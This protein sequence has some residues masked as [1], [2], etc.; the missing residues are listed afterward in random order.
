MRSV[1]ALLGLLLLGCPGSSA[2]HSTPQP[3]AKPEAQAALETV[4]VEAQVLHGK[5]VLQGELSPFEAVALYPRVS[6]FI[7]SIAVDRGSPVRAGQILARLSAPELQAQRAEAEA[8][9]RADELT[10]QRLRTASATPG[11]VAKQELD[12]AEATWRAGVARLASLRAQEQYLVL[13]APFDGLVTERSA[14]PGALVGPPASPTVP[15]LLRIEQLAKLR[16]IVAVPEAYVGAVKQGALVDFT[17][18][19]WPGEKLRATVQ[20]IAHALDTKTRTMPVELDVENLDGRLAPGMFAQVEWPLARTAPSLLVPPSAVVRTT[21]RTFVDRVRDGV[22]EQ[23]PVQLGVTAGERVEVFGALSA[24][25]V[26]LKRGQE[27]LATGSGVQT[28]A[29]NK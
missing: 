13:K 4:K 10:H 17:V 9:A 18:R 21:E 24:G 16:L 7:E 3:P 27:E 26:L 22:V 12:Q 11:A 19:A 15:P 1:L 28:A 25:D 14:H 6:G 2:E 29:G 23:V 20:R 5:T 8:R